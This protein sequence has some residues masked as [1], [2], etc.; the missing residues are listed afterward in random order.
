MN[1]TNYVKQ[2]SKDDF[3]KEFKHTAIWNKRL[4]TTG[5]RFFPKDGHLD[6]NPR[7]YEES[8]LDIFKKIVRHEL[9]HYHLYFEKKGYRHRDADFKQLLKHVDGLRY[10]PVLLEKDGHSH[11]YYS[12]LSCGQFYQR[13]RRINT[14][15][16]SC[17]KC[18]GKL[19]EQ[20]QSQG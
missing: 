12:C 16:F 15:K 5:G 8:G 20:Y 19:V 11:H 14:H 9:C 7:I 2:I 1:L 4:K 18:H 6:F 13:K 17:G 10:A 3:G